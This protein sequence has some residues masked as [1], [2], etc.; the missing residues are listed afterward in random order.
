MESWKRSFIESKKWIIGNYSSIS[1]YLYI[2]LLSLINLKDNFNRLERKKE[3][4]LRENEK[5][6]NDNK[7]QR[8]TFLGNSNLGLNVSRNVD[9]SHHKPGASNFSV[10]A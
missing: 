8:R 2:F 1:T 3:V 9:I 7:N 4:L 6:K 5:L 10:N